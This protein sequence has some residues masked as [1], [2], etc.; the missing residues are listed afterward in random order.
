[1]GTTVYMSGTSLKPIKKFTNICMLLPI[2]NKEHIPLK[3]KQ[4]YAM[5]NLE[6]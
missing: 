1:M 5:A 6:A 2:T 4:Y 3:H